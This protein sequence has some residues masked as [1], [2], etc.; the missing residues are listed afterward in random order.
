MLCSRT[1]KEEGSGL[2]KH[3]CLANES[4]ECFDEHGMPVEC[5]LKHLMSLSK[6]QGEA[7]RL[8]PK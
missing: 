3:E 7:T 1:Y 2:R 6:V 4:L 8:P 5:A